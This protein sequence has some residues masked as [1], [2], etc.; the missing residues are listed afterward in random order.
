MKAT[1]LSTKL[2]DSAGG[3]PGKNQEKK[4]MANQQPLNRKLR[5]DQGTFS[6]EKEEAKVLLST[7]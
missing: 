5:I 7:I 6:Q 4:K 3:F 1:W 2:Q